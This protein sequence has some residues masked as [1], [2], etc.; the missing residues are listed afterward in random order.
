MA[1]EPI[2]LD[3]LNWDQIVTAIRPR[4]VPIPLESG[5]STHPSI[6]ASR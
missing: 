6:P 4:I 3:T 2:Q 5:R 1:L